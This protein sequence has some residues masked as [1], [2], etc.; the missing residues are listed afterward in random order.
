MEIFLFSDFRSVFKDGTFELP[1][2]WDGKDFVK[3]LSE[4]YEKYYSIVSS[5]WFVG[6][7]VR[8]LSSDIKY[9]CDEIINVLKIYL[10]GKESEAFAKFD[11]IF[12]HLMETPLSVYSDFSYDPYLIRNDSKSKYAKLYRV[13]KVQENRNYSKT[14]IF[15]TPFNLRSKVSTNRY[16][17]AGYP[18]LYLSSSVALCL[19]ELEYE[20]NPGRYIASRFELSDIE[21]GIRILELGIKPSDF[22]INYEKNEKEVDRDKEKL[23]RNERQ[24]QLKGI[25]FKDSKIL[26]TYLL[27]YPLL[28]ACAFIRVNKNDPFSVE[29]IIPQMLM[30]SIRLFKTDRVVVGIRYFS[31][32]SIRASDM[33]FNYVFPTKYDGTDDL[34]CKSLKHTF[35]LTEPLL[36]NEYSDIRY[37]ETALKNKKADYII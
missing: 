31:C 10:N 23:K 5:L 33:G 22:F 19:E 13:R 3:T 29:Y 30:Q 15:H 4:L 34:F 17:I 26:K 11:D 21:F 36:L 7:T 35:P 12:K 25:D 8:E 24:E 16:S 9:V 32:S 2:R 28:A 27:W 6:E 14:E 20:F 18:S 37:L 1:I